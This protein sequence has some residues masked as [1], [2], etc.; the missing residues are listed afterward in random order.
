MIVA[1]YFIVPIVDC[2]FGFVFVAFTHAW[3]RKDREL[4]LKIVQLRQALRTMESPRILVSEFR[5]FHSARLDCS[6][7]LMDTHQWYNDRLVPTSKYALWYIKHHFPHGKLLRSFHLILLCSYSHNSMHR[8]MA[9]LL[10]QNRKQ[11]LRI[12]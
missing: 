1:I 9:W 11:G 4:I 10:L 6:S 2:G 8:T 7:S 12:R 3:Q 5:K